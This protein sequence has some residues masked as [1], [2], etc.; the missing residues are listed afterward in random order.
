M[1][2]DCVGFLFYNPF[3]GVSQGSGDLGPF[4]SFASMLQGFLSAVKIIVL[5]QHCIMAVSVLVVLSALS[6]AL[7]KPGEDSSEPDTVA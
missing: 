3:G 4:V 5:V 2:L 6:E 1:L 7:A